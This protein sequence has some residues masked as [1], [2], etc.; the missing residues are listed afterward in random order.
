MVHKRWCDHTQLNLADDTM[1][2]MSSWIKYQKHVCNDSSKQ[3]LSKMCLHQHTVL[4]PCASNPI[5]TP[6]SLQRPT[7]HSF[8]ITR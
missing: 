5:Y 1:T 4:I 3:T 6:S 8:L 2:N 7:F